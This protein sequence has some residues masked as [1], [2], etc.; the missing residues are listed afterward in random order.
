MNTLQVFEDDKFGQIRVKEENGEFLFV[1]KDIC[2]VLDLSDVSMSVSRLDDDE[3]GTNTI[4][5]PGGNQE[6]IVVNEP[7]LYNLILRSRKPEAKQFKR[8]ITH[9]VLPAIRKTGMYAETISISPDT[10]LKTF[11][12]VKKTLDEIN[13]APES[14]LNTAKSIFEKAGIDIPVEIEDLKTTND[15]INHDDEEGTGNRIYVNVKTLRKIRKENDWTTQEMADFIGISRTHLWRLIT[16]K[17]ATGKNSRKKLTES[18]PGYKNVLFV[19]EGY[20]GSERK[21]RPN[22][23]L[24]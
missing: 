23:Y 15:I 3:K 8:W 21:D 6:M 12:E 16:R 5:T 7:G 14:K 13:A 2:N 4:C 24:V 18:F 10:A 17:C 1:A 19:E 9:E 20:E 11:K 22:L